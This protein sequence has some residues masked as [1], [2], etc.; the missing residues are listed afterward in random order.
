MPHIDHRYVSFKIL[1]K[2][3]KKSSKQQRQSFTLAMYKN[4]LKTYTSALSAYKKQTV[5]Y[6]PAPVSTN[7]CIVTTRAKIEG[8]FTNLLAVKDIIRYI[9]WERSQY[10]GKT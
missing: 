10:K 6:Q 1:G 8:T 7:K 4:L 9:L 3:L 2:N 5:I